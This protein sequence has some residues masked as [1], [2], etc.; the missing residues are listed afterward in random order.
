VCQ[1]RKSTFFHFFFS[2]KKS[3][4]WLVLLDAKLLAFA[5]PS[6]VCWCV[7]E[8]HRVQNSQLRVARATTQHLWL[9]SA[10]VDGVA[11]SAVT[12]A[13]RFA[14]RA[15]LKR[16]HEMR[17]WRTIL[18]RARRAH[19]W[20]HWSLLAQ[21]DRPRFA[22]PVVASLSCADAIAIIVARLACASVVKV[23]FSRPAV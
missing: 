4:F 21:C 6:V 22:L 16:W 20:L 2:V 9:A 8:T 7:Q 13:R 15:V 5:R 3:A 1:M 23:G 17:V 14:Q 18:P 19:D 11:A 10:R 12:N